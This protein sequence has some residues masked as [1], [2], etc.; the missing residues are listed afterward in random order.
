MMRGP[1]QAGP[2]APAQRDLLAD[3]P[4]PPIS[5]PLIADF[6]SSATRRKRR[7]RRLLA[8]AAVIVVVA[9]GAWLW[10][11]GEPSTEAVVTADRHAGEGQAGVRGRCRQNQI[12]VLDP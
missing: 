10:T 5:E 2:A 3:L 6:E 4:P 8:A 1:G 9:L 7:N 12:Q 11:G